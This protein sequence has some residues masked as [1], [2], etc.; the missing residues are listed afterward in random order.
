MGQSPSK[1]SAI[2]GTCHARWL[3]ASESAATRALT[4]C[5]GVANALIDRLSTG[6]EHRDGS[7]VTTTVRGSKPLRLGP[8]AVAID[9]PLRNQFAQNGIIR[10]AEV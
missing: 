3:Q 2:S 9:R 7:R 6:F 5:L 8:V 4:H 10:H 1:D